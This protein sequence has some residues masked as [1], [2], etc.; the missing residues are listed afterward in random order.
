MKSLSSISLTFE[1]MNPQNGID[2]N[3]N[4]NDN[5][6]TKAIAA[7]IPIVGI[8]VATALLSGLSLINGYY[9]PATAQQNMTGTNATIPPAGANVTN[10]TAAGA[11]VTNVTA[12]GANVTNVTAAGANVTNVTAAGANV[13]NATNATAAG[14]NVTNVTGGNMTT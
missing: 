12:A 7:A 10:V 6:T 13:T 3:K 8:L 11:N 5:H 9:Q 14:A 1:L 2:D 4:D